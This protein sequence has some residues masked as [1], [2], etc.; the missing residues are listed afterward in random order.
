[1]GRKI[2]IRNLCAFGHTVAISPEIGDFL[3][4]KGAVAGL[5]HNNRQKIILKI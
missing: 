1:M 4:E 5:R 2:K 3:L